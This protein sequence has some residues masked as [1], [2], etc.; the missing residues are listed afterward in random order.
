MET[1]P[2]CLEITQDVSDVDVFTYDR[3]Y[4][5]LHEIGAQASG[6]AKLV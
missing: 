3:E 4:S 2:F 6:L 1:P 5:G